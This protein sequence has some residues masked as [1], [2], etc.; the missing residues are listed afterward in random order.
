M[1]LVNKGLASDFS[2]A[3]Y[4]AVAGGTPDGAAKAV[5]ASDE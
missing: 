5:F 1:V 3:V 2:P 4:F